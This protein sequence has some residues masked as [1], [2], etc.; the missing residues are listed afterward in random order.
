MSIT[1]TD[2]DPFDDLSFG[3]LLRYVGPDHF[4]GEWAAPSELH[5]P[6]EFRHVSVGGTLTLETRFNG[7]RYYAPEHPANDR[8]Y[9][10]VVDDE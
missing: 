8:D 1:T 4:D 6:Y 10:E 3:D 7:R 2:T 5:G 9:W